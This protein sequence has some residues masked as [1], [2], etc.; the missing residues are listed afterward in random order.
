MNK[1][2]V[3][4]ISTPVPVENTKMNIIRRATLNLMSQEQLVNELGEVNPYGEFDAKEKERLVT[5]PKEWLIE[6]IEKAEKL[7]NGKYQ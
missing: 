1:N 3:K 5:L 6:L 4:I 2:K 7:T